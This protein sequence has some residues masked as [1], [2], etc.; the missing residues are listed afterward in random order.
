[1]SDPSLLQR[2]A[3]PF[4]GTQYQVLR[5][6]FEKVLFGRADE[7]ASDPGA[8]AVKVPFDAQLWLRLAPRE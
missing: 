6:T 3:A 8:G 1:L 2:L 5:V 4:E 7:Y